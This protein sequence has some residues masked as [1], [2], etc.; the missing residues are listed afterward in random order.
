MIISITFYRKN[1]GAWN[2]GYND[3]RTIRTNKISSILF[4]HINLYSY[5]P[6]PPTPIQVQNQKNKKCL[7]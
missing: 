5:A 3:D 1:K 4:L 6:T 2:K 7:F